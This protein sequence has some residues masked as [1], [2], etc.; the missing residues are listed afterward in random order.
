MSRIGRDSGL[1]AIADLVRVPASVLRPA[2]HAA[3]TPAI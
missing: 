1:E 2:F 3:A